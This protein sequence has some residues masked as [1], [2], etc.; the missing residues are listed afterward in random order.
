MGWIA[1]AL[2]ALT[3]SVSQLLNKTVQVLHIE[4]INNK[5][6]QQI[7]ADNQLIKHSIT[8]VSGKLD[9]GSV[10]L[11]QVSVKDDVLLHYVKTLIS[12]LE[13]SPAVTFTATIKAD[14]PLQGENM[15]NGNLK[16]SAD[17][18]INDNGTATIQLQFQDADGVNVPPPAGIQVQYG[19]ASDENPGPSSFT[20]TPSQDTLSCQVVVVQPPPQPLHTGVTFTVTVPSGLAGQTAPISVQTD[21][22]LDVVP[23]PASSFVAAVSEP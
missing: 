14:Q 21:P 7:L 4:R 22:P 17:I 6:L 2:L 9:A 13:P 10:I 1:R 5:L 20:L 12:L 23:G 8:Q 19:P 15:A 3:D 18:S 16:A 11:T